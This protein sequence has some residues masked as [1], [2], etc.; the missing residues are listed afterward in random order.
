MAPCNG[1][2]P[3]SPSLSTEIAGEKNTK[4]KHFVVCVCAMQDGMT[5]FWYGTALYAR[6]VFAS[7]LE[8]LYACIFCKMS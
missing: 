6:V 2:G 7:G 1:G 5:S 4:H 8:I 3:L